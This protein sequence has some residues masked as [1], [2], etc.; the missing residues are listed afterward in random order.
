MDTGD[1]L[2]GRRVQ[3]Q[4][5]WA[6]AEGSDADHQL[7]CD[8]GGGVRRGGDLRGPQGRLTNSNIFNVCVC[9]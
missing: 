9:A 2:M 5:F 3:R 6:H 1:D 4:S 7:P 8:R